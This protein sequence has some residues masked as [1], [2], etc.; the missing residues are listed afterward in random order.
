M[1][2]ERLAGG[3]YIV[4][5][6]YSISTSPVTLILTVLSFSV[7]AENSNWS[8]IRV[9]GIGLGFDSRQGCLLPLDPDEDLSNTVDIDTIRV[10][11]INGRF[12]RHHEGEPTHYDG[13]PVHESCWTILK[14]RFQP[15]PVAL[16]HA[17]FSMPMRANGVLSWGCGLRWPP[18]STVLQ[19]YIHITHSNPLHIQDIDIAR[20]HI[21]EEPQVNSYVGPVSDIFGSLAVEVRAQVLGYL[22]TPDVCHARIASRSLNQVALPSSFYKSRFD[23]GFEYHHIFELREAAP[24]CWRSFFEWMRVTSRH[25][26]N[27]KS[28]ERIWTISTK[29][30]HMHDQIL[31]TPCEGTPIATDFEPNGGPDN[32]G[33]DWKTAAFEVSSHVNTSFTSGCRV[34]H[35]RAVIFGADTKFRGVCVSL[36]TT[37][38]E[39]NVSGLR[40]LVDG[41]QDIR[42][43]Y[44]HPATEMSVE[45]A[46]PLAINA[47]S[48][49]LDEKGIKA[50]AVNG[51]DVPRDSPKWDGD[52]PVLPAWRISRQCPV[53]AIRAQFDVCRLSPSCH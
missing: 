20:G 6:R 11:F 45:F 7:Y 33:F 52:S 27:T 50:I 9:T 42:I 41:G 44:I 3:D 30:K 29:L 21:I 14:K 43:G 49:V 37:L 15:N 17:W 53:T 28:R 5:V 24:D 1:Q 39:R 25:R 32:F 19:D 40:F 12:R 4:L 18:S 48:L 26:R 51:L 22:P 13:F 38:E 34:M 2:T 35:T 36:Y 31:N 10:D 23:E 8:D 47:F 46:Q 16:F